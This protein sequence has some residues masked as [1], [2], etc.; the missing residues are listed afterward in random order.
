MTNVNTQENRSGECYQNSSQDPRG[1]FLFIPFQVN[2]L[3]N[4]KVQRR[5]ICLHQRMFSLQIGCRHEFHCERSAS[6][7]ECVCESRRRLVRNFLSGPCG[8]MS[9]INNLQI[10]SPALSCTTVCVCRSSYASYRPG[11]SSKSGRNI[12]QSVLF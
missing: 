9:S 1:L 3:N 8:K 5:S 4:G 6:T 2:D 7:F 10:K 11:K 12:F